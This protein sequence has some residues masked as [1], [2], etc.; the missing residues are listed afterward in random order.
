VS[1][2]ITAVDGELIQ[3]IK[4]MLLMKRTVV[5]L[6]LWISSYAGYA[7]SNPDSCTMEISLLTCAPGSDLYSI[8]GHTAI[9]I[10]DSRRGM[11]I[12]YN[13][14][15]FDDSDPLFYLKFMRGIMRYSLSAE[16]F[17][18]FMQE[19]DY[20]SREVVAQILDLNCQEK[21]ELYE[22]LRINTL[23]D[24]RI[25]DYHF[26]TDNCTTRAGKIIASHAGGQLMYKNILPDPPPSYR[27]MIHEYLDPQHQ[28][29]SEFGIDMFLG[30]NLDIKPSN[31][32]A[33]YFLP[34]YLFKGMD[35]ASVRN[36]SLVQ[37]KQVL[38]QFPEKKKPGEGLTP[39]AV[40]ICLLLATIMLFLFRESPAIARTQLIFDIVFFSLLG[41]TGLLMAAMWLG[42]VDDVCRN[43]FNILW[44]LPTHIIA[45]FFIRK[46]ASWIKYYFLITAIVACMLLIGF[47]WWS[48]RMN[49][50][51]VPILAII[52][53]R[54][55]YFYINRKHAEKSVIQG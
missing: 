46:K 53:F 33:I 11:D 54:S 47:P 7:Q 22:A 1:P 23:E 35:S 9:R 2:P 39:K 30:K 12:V 15:T 28:D 45:V 10:K 49:P 41:L 52:I 19:Y 27:D 25:Y 8:F 20:E 55:F 36:K 50:A 34:D 6:L 17:E 5:F 38:L 43:N 13:Y 32:G 48:Q 14:G 44:A 51:V 21:K 26:H 16:T 24:N 37:R 3:S 31:E 42:R 18:N 40:F 29:W 4:I